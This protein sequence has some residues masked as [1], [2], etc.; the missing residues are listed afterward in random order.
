MNTYI[1]IFAG[2]SIFL[3]ALDMIK[4]HLN[5]MF[6]NRINH[7]LHKVTNSKTK[8]FLFGCIAAA[9]I[10]SSSGVSAISISL[11]STKRI[12][13]AECLGIIIGANLG[14]CLTAFITA[15]N[16][17]NISLIILIISFFIYLIFKNKRHYCIFISY[18]G[19]MLLGLDILKMGFND[20]LSKPFIYQIIQNVQNSFTLSLLFGIS[21]TAIIQ[22]SSGIISIVE[23]MYDANLINL[24]CAIIIMLGSNIGTTFTGYLATINT[25]KECKKIVN[26]NLIFNIIGVIIF[27][28]LFKPF[29]KFNLHLQSNFFLYNNKMIIA[30]AHF[31]FN[32]ITVFLGYIF[33]PLFS[34]FI[35]NK[36][37]REEKKSIIHTIS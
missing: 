25:S 26:A 14:T 36:L 5:N 13:P 6:S 24:S 29:L 31:L 17:K 12:K 27:I 18:I 8:S 23:N 16:I 2:L 11:L 22:S 7:I 20:I 10:Q 28:V 37:T 3:L 1:L 34:P 19:F 4:N 32:L 21:S 33:F 35:K 15:I 9:I 30:V